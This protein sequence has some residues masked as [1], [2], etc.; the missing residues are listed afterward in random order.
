[1]SPNS[2]KIFVIMLFLLGNIC[3]QTK[4]VV[5]REFN[6]SLDKTIEEIKQDALKYLMDDALKQVSGIDVQSYDIFGKAESTSEV[7]DFFGKIIKTTVK[8][9]VTN[10]K[11][12]AEDIKQNNNSI[13]YFLRLEA[14][15]IKRSCR[16]RSIF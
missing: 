6:F 5:E 16:K 10:Y 8:G 14:V 12:L 1:M 9:R 15:V 7:K 11:I 4:V 2:L 13:T 3:A